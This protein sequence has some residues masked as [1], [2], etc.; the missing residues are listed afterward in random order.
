LLKL[1]PK[2]KKKYCKVFT[3]TITISES[4][5]LYKQKIE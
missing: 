5:Y 2:R 3:N 1:I 4:E